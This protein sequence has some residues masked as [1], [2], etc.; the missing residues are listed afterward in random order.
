[1]YRKIAQKIQVFIILYT[2]LSK[3]DNFIS[4]AKKKPES[5]E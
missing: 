3:I 4:V 1:M 2:D 5:C